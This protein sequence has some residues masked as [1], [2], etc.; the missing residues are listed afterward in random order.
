M[1]V[2]F[3]HRP[4]ITVFALALRKSAGNVLPPVA[5]HVLRARTS[6]SPSAF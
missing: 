1:K 4:L 2:R 6:I 3:L 5:A